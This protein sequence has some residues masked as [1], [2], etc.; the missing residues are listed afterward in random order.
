MFVIVA[1]F[2]IKPEKIADFHK[3]I[4]KQAEASVAEEAGCLQFD[5]VQSEENPAAF[6]LYEV[7]ANAAAFDEDH[8]TIPRFEKFLAEANTMVAED[9]L[10]RRMT[11]IF[12]NAE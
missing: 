11:R 3:V 5:V 1:E 4:G 6:I 9:P 8:I 12:A 7:Y 10:V 2:L